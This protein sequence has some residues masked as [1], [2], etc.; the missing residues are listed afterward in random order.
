MQNRLCSRMV[1]SDPA[2]KIT[3]LRHSVDQLLFYAAGC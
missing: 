1:T 2:D 3:R